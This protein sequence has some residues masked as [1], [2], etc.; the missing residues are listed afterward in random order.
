MTDQKTI[1]PA[2]QRDSDRRWRTP[3]RTGKVQ[4]KPAPAAIAE[5]RKSERIS[6]GT[7]SGWTCSEKPERWAELS[8]FTRTPS[9]PMAARTSMTCRG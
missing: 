3:L 8:P 2:D 6:A 5:R 4:A 9:V 7:C 1:P